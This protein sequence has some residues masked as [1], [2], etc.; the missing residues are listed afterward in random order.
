M[1]L[2]ACIDGF[3]VVNIVDINTEDQ[4]RELA[5]KHSSVID[6]TPVILKPQVGWV[7][8]GVVFTPPASQQVNLA[9]LVGDRIKHYQSLAPQ[10]LVDMYVSN[11]LAG[12]NAEQSSQMFT[13]YGDVLHCIREGA[14]PTAIYKLAQKQP[15][16]F[17]TQEMIDSWTA[18]IQGKLL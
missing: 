10:I 6:L 3:T 15:E 9:Q 4:Y 16:G 18:L 17:V 1:A 8:Q 12:I 2:H 7:L 13:D 5:G 11:T 14:W